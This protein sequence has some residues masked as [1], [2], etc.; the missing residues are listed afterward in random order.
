MNNK[1]FILRNSRMI[2]WRILLDKTPW[3]HPHRSLVV[4]KNKKTPVTYIL[5]YN[6][7]T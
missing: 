7:L 1:Q 2:G 3:H 5:E 6:K 4:K